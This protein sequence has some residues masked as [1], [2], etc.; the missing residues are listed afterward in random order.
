MSG[1]KQLSIVRD[2]SL[3][4]FTSYSLLATRYSL[5][6]TSTAVLADWRNSR[7]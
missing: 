6:P 7:W 1:Q 3:L 5:L 2:I 4:S